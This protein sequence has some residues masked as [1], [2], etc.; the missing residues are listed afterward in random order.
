MTVDNRLH[1]SHAADY[2]WQHLMIFMLCWLQ[3]WSEAKIKQEAIFIF[4]HIFC[5]AVNR[6]ISLIALI[7]RYNSALI[8]LLTY[9]FFVTFCNLFVFHLQVD[10]VG[11]LLLNASLLLV[12]TTDYSDWLVQVTQLTDNWQWRSLLSFDDCVI[13]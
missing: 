10:V 11:P 8:V 1:Q 7:V 2:S 13:E 6:I 5:T 9:I 12:L 4:E 3:L